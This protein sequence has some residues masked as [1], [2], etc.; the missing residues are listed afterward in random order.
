M[1]LLTSD[2]WVG[3]SEAARVLGVSAQWVI[4]LAHQGVLHCEMTPLDRIFR[5]ADVERLAAARAKRRE[6]QARELIP[7]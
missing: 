4:R 5:R 3:P 7:A 6:H 1:S 2:Q